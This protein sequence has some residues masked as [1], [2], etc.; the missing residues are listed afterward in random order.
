MTLDDSCLNEFL[1]FVGNS[2]CMHVID[3]LC[4]VAGCAV[5]EEQQGTGQRVEEEVRHSERQRHHD[6]LPQLLGQHL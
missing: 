2:D 6:L 3:V 4:C 5:Q 1:T